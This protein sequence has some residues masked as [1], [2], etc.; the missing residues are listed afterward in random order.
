MPQTRLTTG[1]L[2]IVKPLQKEA[3]IWKLSSY[4]FVFTSM[5]TTLP[6]LTR[7]SINF[8]LQDCR[9]GCS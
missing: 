1:K 5:S 6:V 2:G 7:E 4:A 9:V 8:Y 3:H